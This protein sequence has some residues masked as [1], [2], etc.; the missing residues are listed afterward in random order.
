MKLKRIAM[1]LLI[2]GSVLAAQPVRAGLISPWQPPQL[3][4]QTTMRVTQPIVLTDYTDHVH[5]FW[6]E[7]PDL[8]Q[9]P[10][11]PTVIFHVDNTSGEWSE[12]VDILMPPDGATSIE[13]T[14]DPY[15][16]IH[17][18]WYGGMNTWY[19][20]SADSSQANEPHSWSIPNKLAVG[21]SYGDLLADG[22]GGLHFVYPGYE[23]EGIFYIFSG[24]G[25]FSW[26]LPVNISP[27]ASSQ[28]AAN[29][30]QLA[31][32]TNGGLHAAWS[33]FELPNGWPPT[34]VYY[35]SSSDGGQTWEH[36]RALAKDGYVQ[37]TL[38]AGQDGE[39]FAGWNAMVS[40]GGRYFAVTRDGGNTWS[41]V[42]AI[43]PPK[44]SGMSG[45]PDMTSDASGSLYLVTPLSGINY[46]NY[47]ENGW[48]EPQK[49]SGDLVAERTGSIELPRIAVSHGNRLHVVFEVDFKA[50]YYTS[51]ITDAP[52]FERQP[53]PT[54]TA[55]VIE[56]GSSVETQEPTPIA[57]DLDFATRASKNNNL[58]SDPSF[59]ILIAT[60][61]VVAILLAIVAVRRGK[62]N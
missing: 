7:G 43:V 29:Y 3:L 61:P 25:G 18:V 39:V 57:S 59:P 15:N 27:P 52:Q 8:E 10:D 46:L 41:E 17:L 51:A 24:D 23:N 47:V 22:N 32:D 21:L 44:S 13:A 34:G 6:L 5:I 33:E 12:P 28:S 36:Q 2:I 20:T 9:A 4:Y 45:Y 48:T 14:I 26:S 11:A 1:L 49:I 62:S 31:I 53:L 38:Q 60:L 54:P 56:A 35:A 40:I 16:R 58:P 50:I 19:Y 55:K 42:M 37:V 30:T